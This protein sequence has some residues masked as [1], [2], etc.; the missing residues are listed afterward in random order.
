MDIQQQHQLLAR[1]SQLE[2]SQRRMRYGLG[3]V[4]MIFIA[5]I[6]IGA[7]EK[8]APAGALEAQELVIKDKAGGERIKMA[9]DESGPY[10]RLYDSRGLP[11][12]SLIVEDAGAT[13]FMPGGN[14]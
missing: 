11:R 2:R 9:V 14:T 3:C 10:L 7:E 12:A 13:L 5:M 4:A 8:G 6:G 1:L